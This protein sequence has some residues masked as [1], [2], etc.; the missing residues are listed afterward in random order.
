MVKTE[1]ISKLQGK[2]P[3]ILAIIIKFNGL[4]LPVWNPEKFE[5]VFF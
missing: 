5:I 2:S 3:N 4:N 1:N